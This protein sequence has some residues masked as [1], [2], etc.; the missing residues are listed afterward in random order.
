MS[1]KMFFLRG[2]PRPGP[3][4]APRVLILK[5][6]LLTKLDGTL[7]LRVVWPNNWYLLK[8]Y[9]LADLL[10]T[11]NVYWKC[12]ENFLKPF[13]RKN[14]HEI[15]ENP[16]F[17]MKLKPN[18]TIEFLRFLHQ[19]SIFLTTGEEVRYARSIYRMII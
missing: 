8:A 17:T 11:H 15:D 19:F 3:V 2:G 16:H 1:I 5:Q 10:N 9:D 7:V 4:L 14:L 6:P 12:V 18:E 13:L